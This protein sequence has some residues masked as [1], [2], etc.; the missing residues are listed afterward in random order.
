MQ[1]NIGKISRAID[2]D[3]SRFGFD[4]SALSPQ[5]AYVVRYGLTQSLNDAHAAEK[6]PDDGSNDDAIYAIVEK[7][8]EAIYT[9]I[10]QRVGAP[11]DPVGAEATRLARAEIV[12]AMRKAGKKVSAYEP[13]AINAAV[14]KHLDANRERI[15][16]K[17]AENVAAA[18]EIAVDLDEIL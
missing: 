4:E 12:A 6:R 9:G 7:K 13:A 16:A 5:A 15:M 8:L 17:A 18:G 2:V 10:S 1:I 3:L 11:R 14:A